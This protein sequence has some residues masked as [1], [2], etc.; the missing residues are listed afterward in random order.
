MQNLKQYGCA[1]EAL[2]NRLSIDRN[3]RSIFQHIQ[4]PIPLMDVPFFSDFRNLQENLMIHQL[5]VKLLNKRL[6]IDR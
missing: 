4:L 3:Y 1:K 6:L 2:S 5:T